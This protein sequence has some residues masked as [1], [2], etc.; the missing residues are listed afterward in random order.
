MR[1]TRREFMRRTA[2]AVALGALKPSSVRAMPREYTLRAA[3]SRA[4]IVGGE[5]PDTPVWSYDG[6]VPGPELRV[7]AGESL[8]VHFENG[9]EQ[10][11]TVHWHGIRLP[12]AMDGVPGLTQP[13]VAP[14]ESFVYEFTPP[15]AGTFWY[16]P[17]VR[18]FEQVA[19]GLSGV[20]IVEEPE[21]LPV[22]REVTWVL[23]DWRLTPE[24]AI[25][26]DFGAGHDVSHAG[27]IGNTVTVNGRIMD[28]FEVHAGERVRLRLVN[29]ANA[30]TFGLDFEGLTPVVIAIDG[31]P[32]TPH[33]PADGMVVLGAAMR[34][35]LLLDCTGAPGS[36][37][38]VVDR[39]Y[40]RW[41]YELT[42]L[43]YAGTAPLRD[44]PDAVVA[45]APNPL[46]EPDPDGA[47]ERVVVLAGG[48][49]G[50]MKG[51]QLDGQW[52]DMRTLVSNGLVWAMDGVARRPEARGDAMLVAPR[53]S[54][55]VI[56]LRND[57]AFDHPMHLHGHHFRVVARN[58]QPTAYRQWQDTVLVSP[59]EEVTIAFRADNPGDWLFH[60]HVLEHQAA[61]MSAV[62]RVA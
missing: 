14:G 51:A 9:L 16:H 23:D 49:M 43:A 28:R 2:G 10:P 40:R 47:E 50:Q 24:A 17:H 32:V 22:D 3:P 61:G 34:V 8:R 30:R 60:C 5:I 42:E 37:S 46:P 48:A 26:E 35:D 1:Q 58:G 6:R 62:L 33:E 56:K 21:P 19:R 25:E 57:S 13:A 53:G 29:V 36:R 54:T 45:L 41:A 39:F 7:R 27:R 20:L 59:R 12:N 44:R 4:P 55:H 38:R 18:G 11:T 52:A 31:Q 15:D